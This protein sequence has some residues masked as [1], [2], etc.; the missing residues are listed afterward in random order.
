MA[1]AAKASPPQDVGLPDADVALRAIIARQDENP[2]YWSSKTRDRSDSAHCIFQYPAMMVPLVQRRLLAAVREAQPSACNLYDPFLGSGTSLVS[3]MHFGLDVYGND[4]NPLAILI[5]RTRTAR[6][7]EFG[8]GQ[9]AM[10][11]VSAARADRK[12]RIETSLVNREKWFKDDV[13]LELSRLRRAIQACDNQWVRRFMWVTL[14]ETVRLTSNDRTSTYKLHA[15]PKEE[16]EKRRLSPIDV[17]SD[18]AIQNA[19]SFTAF[20]NA[21]READVLKNGRYVGSSDARIGDSRAL[22]EMTDW[23]PP[24]GFQRVMTSPPYGDN[25]TTVTYGQHAY[26]PLHW[27]DLADIDEA[28][29]LDSIR[30][31]QEID[32][33]GLGGRHRQDLADAEEAL[34]AVAPSLKR[35][36]E[37]L[38]GTPADARTRLVR[39]YTDFRDTLTALT[40]ALAANAY[41]IW[42]VGNR[43]LAS[44]QVPTDKILGELLASQGCTLVTTLNRTIHHKRMAVRNASSSTMREEYIVLVRKNGE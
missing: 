6:K 11:V 27:I 42:T 16:I 17:F 32:R 29:S 26:L 12:R 19:K 7:F 21:L 30:T 1:R 40:P 3:G 10:S 39:F 23:P 8:V 15:R 24:G 22:G 2:D 34:F 5:S 18:L 43:S 36:A 38:P 41:M 37:A 35:F 44:K 4:V 28:A 31:T 20:Q 25:L 14:A 13:A 9:S 33:R